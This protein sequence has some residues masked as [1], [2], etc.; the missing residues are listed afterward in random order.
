MSIDIQ[1][2]RHVKDELREAVERILQSTSCRKLVVAGPGAGKT[3]LFRQLLEA[4]PGGADSR[5]VLTFINNLK[6]D[7]Q[8]TLGGLAHVNTLHGYCQSLLRTHPELRSGITANFICLPGL[9]S[10]IK[11]DWEHIWGAPAPHFVTLMRDLTDDDAIDFYLERANFYDAVDFDDSVFRT[12]RSLEEHP[13]AVSGLDLIL[14]DEYQDFNRM[15][16]TFIEQL[17]R[18]NPIVVAGDDDQALYGELRGASWEHIRSLHNGELYEKFALPFCMRCPEVIVNAISDILARARENGFLQGRID[19]PYR[20]YAPRKGADSLLYPSI[21]KVTTTV[22]RNNANYFGR[23]IA[24]AIGGIPAN[25]IQEA[26]QSSEPTVLII[27]SRQYRHPVENYLI[28]R[29]YQVDIGSKE[30]SDLTR[31]KGLELLKDSPESNLGWRVILNF[32]TA[33]RERAWI[34]TANEKSMNLIEVIPADLRDAVLT[35]AGTWTPP[36]VSNE[37]VM[38]DEEAPVIKLTTF[39]GAKGLS[40]QHVFIL[41]MHDGDMPQNPDR[42]EDIEICKFVVGLTRTKKRCTLMLSRRF[43][44]DQKTPSRFLSWIAPRRYEPIAVD[45]AYL[46]ERGW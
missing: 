3:T 43:A 30:S 13:N 31:D 33:E 11:T 46:A 4:A 38:V 45:A 17:A 20:H 16:A 34:R 2:E 24:A 42:I 22:Q 40:A 8:R 27:G 37:E 6:N 23:Y 28:E 21:V 36:D 19:K 18:Q 25:E 35:E 12:C 32:E 7:L 39:E 41:G 10:L 1:E 44:A 9:A 26:R 29:G 5:L 15:E 14:I